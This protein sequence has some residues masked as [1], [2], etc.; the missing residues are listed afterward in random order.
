MTIMIAAFCTRSENDYRLIVVALV[1]AIVPIAI[2]GIISPDFDDV[3]GINPLEGISNKNGFSVFA[4]PAILLGGHFFLD[5]TPTNKFVRWFVGGSVLLIVFA[6]FSSGN[7][8][9][10]LGVGIVFVSFMGIPRRRLKGFTWVALAAAGVAYAVLHYG[11]SLVLENRIEGSRAGYLSDDL[12]RDLFSNAIL[13]GLE[14]PMFGVTPQRLPFE[15]AH[16]VHFHLS[17]VDP[18]NVFGFIVGGSGLIT[19]GLLAYVGYLLYS[20]MRGKPAAIYKEMGVQNAV[21]IARGLVWIW[22][23]RGM[24]SREIL[25]NPAFCIAL[26]AC[27]AYRRVHEERAH[28]EYAASRPPTPNPVPRAALVDPPRIYG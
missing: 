28:R 27:F 19:T 1:A 18:H 6:I 21:Y 12:R 11:N 15:L 13:I 4:L 5:P 20:H 25:Y 8:S 2:R 22:C 24:F 3:R 9:G 14:N 17:A 26:G 7:R 10:W 23:V 16:R